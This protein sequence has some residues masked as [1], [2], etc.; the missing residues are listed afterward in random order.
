[1]FGSHCR[2][3]MSKIYWTNAVSRS[4]MKPYGFG[5]SVSDHSLRQSVDCQQFIVVRQR[6]LCVPATSFTKYIS[7]LR[8]V[9]KG[10]FLLAHF[11]ST[12]CQRFTSGMEPC[13]APLSSQA[14][15]LYCGHQRLPC[16]V[17]PNP[18]TPR[19]RGSRCLVSTSRWSPTWTMSSCPRNRQAVGSGS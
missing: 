12:P 5:G 9:R 18:A 7:K 17:A 16:E 2:F 13:C 4:A 11:V 8:A 3:G 19:Y 6:R 15:S 10:G 1:M 14:R